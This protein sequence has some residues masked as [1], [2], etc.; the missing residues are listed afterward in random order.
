[1]IWY[2]QTGFLLPMEMGPGK[3]QPYARFET[4]EV[5]GA[6]DTNFW[7]GGLNYYIR[8]HNAKI[9]LDVTHVNQDKRSSTVDHTT[10]GTAQVTLGF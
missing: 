10:F 5:D 7:G 8:G 1:M 6:K 2:A 4:I 9:S 3:L